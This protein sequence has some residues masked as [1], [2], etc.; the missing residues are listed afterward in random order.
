MLTFTFLCFIASIAQDL[1]S[2]E[3]KLYDIIM[4]YR[5]ANDLP[6]IPLS[7][8]LTT[9]AKTHVKDLM[10]NS[11]NQGTCN[12]H[13]WSD[14]GNWTPCC[15]TGD[16]KRL[17]CVLNKPRELTPYQAKAYEIAFWSS[18]NVTAIGALKGWKKSKG[19]NSVIINEDNWHN[20]N[21]KAIGIGIFGNYAVV[22]F[23][24]VLDEL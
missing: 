4:E 18:S 6:V 20:N 19:H 1:S 10:T 23:G 16:H 7:K 11:P 15:Y 21:W 22:W 13:S 5:K 9:V 17:R 2:E 8:S 3:Q 12:L 14:K 24:G